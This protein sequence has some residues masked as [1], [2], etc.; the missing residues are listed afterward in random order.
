MVTVTGSR[1]R[2]GLAPRVP[3][4]RLLVGSACVGVAIL[5]GVTAVIDAGG[6]LIDHPAL[7]ITLRT[8]LVVGLVLIA[9]VVLARGSNRRLATLLLALAYAFVLTGLTGSSSPAWFTLG[10]VAVAAGLLLTLYLSC[11]YPSGR[12]DDRLARVVF[13]TGAVVLV[14]LQAASLLISD[15]A[16][17]SGP[18]VR[19]TGAA[20]PANPFNVFSVAD[21]AS[22][23]LST[24]LAVVTALAVCAAAF[25]IA[26]RTFA[27][28]RVQRRTLAPMCVWNVVA[29]LAFGSFVAVRAL[30]I[31]APLLG[32]GAAVVAALLA[33]MPVAI[34]IGIARGRMLAIGGLEHMI[35]ELGG[36]PTLAEL[37]HTA[38]HAFADPTLALFVW[39]PLRG[40]YLDSGGHAVD[41]SSVGGGRT[42]TRFDDADGYSVAAAAHDPVLS[43]DPDVLDAAGTAIR[44]T[45]DNARLQTDLSA[46]IREL[47]ASRQ[48]V[49]WAADEER[50]RIEQDLHD[51]AQQDLIGLRIK[52]DRL[53]SLVAGD[54]AALGRGIADAGRRIDLAIAHIRDLA[55]GIYPSVLRDLGLH[56]ALSAVARDLP[57][58]LT[59]RGR[60]PRFTPEVETAV[61]F[62]CLE[63]LQNVAKH[64]GPDA[65]ASLSLSAHRGQLRFTIADDGPGFDAGSAATSRG[66]TNMRD[67]IAAVGGELTITS[68]P[69]GGTA[70]SGRVPTRG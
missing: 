5:A 55:K 14:A 36:H 21:A 12:I 40:Q 18:F 13:M 52:L 61:Y 60:P 41:L 29:A 49:A 33:A 35:A 57:V 47:E 3:E 68:A 64:A 16:P 27:A 38:A 31:H 30:D 6:S 23:T 7:F 2:P 15:M 45:L 4:Q 9:L 58:D 50:R 46:Y 24:A 37:E 43:D 70:V 22:D 42:I 11:S 66:L 19:C 10:R 51:G 26:R 67:R 63:A 8:L 54:P 65:R 25:V 34:A 17:I 1:I 62:T 20:C 44:L 69:G 53:E 32:P 39:H 28:S 48:R 56:A 59:L